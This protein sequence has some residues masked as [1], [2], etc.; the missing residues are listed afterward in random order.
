MSIK[1]D[2]TINEEDNQ[3][4]S[5]RVNNITFHDTFNS[6]FYTQN[7]TTFYDK[8]DKGMAAVREKRRVKKRQNRQKT[9]KLKD[10][11]E[12]IAPNREEHDVRNLK[13][14]EYEQDSR[15]DADKYIQNDLSGMMK[16]MKT[17]P[18]AQALFNE[19]VELL[20]HKEETKNE[21]E[22]R[23]YQE[24]VKQRLK[25]KKQ[26]EEI[27]MKYNVLYISSMLPSAL[28]MH[29]FKKCM[30]KDPL[31][32]QKR[33][34]IESKLDTQSKINRVRYLEGNGKVA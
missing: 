25:S 24:L 15:N 7:G 20:Q 14:K 8:E 27:E 5:T 22:A 30:S 29:K 23:K 17:N 19:A 26:K 13:E 18:K 21:V 28:D 31:Y 2:D 16:M 11:I 6:T 12:R 1:Q 3:T 10:F 33:F 4:H 34:K 9:R 32:E